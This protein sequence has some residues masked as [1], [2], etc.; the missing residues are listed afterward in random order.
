MANE[1]NKQFSKE[2]VEMTNK[3][4]KKRSTSLAKKEM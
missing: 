3:H 4:M 1:L 2:E